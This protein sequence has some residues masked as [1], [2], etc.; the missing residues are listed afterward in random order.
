MEKKRIPKYALKYKSRGKKT[1]EG[2]EK[3]GKKQVGIG[4]RSNP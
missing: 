4:A 2:R 1:Q 3:D